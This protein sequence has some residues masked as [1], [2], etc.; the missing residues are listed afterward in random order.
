MIFTITRAGALDKAT[1]AG[2]RC[3]ATALLHANCSDMM[4]KE[5]INER[6]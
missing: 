6:H 5:G 3:E 4:E 1:C 2:Q